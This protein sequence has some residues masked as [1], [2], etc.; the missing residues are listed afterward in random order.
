MA[1]ICL[2]RNDNGAKKFRN[3]NVRYDWEIIADLTQLKF[4][5]I[6]STI[7]DI[8]SGARW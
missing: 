8:D 1:K 2:Q 5:L 4:M 6:H 7:R 3:M